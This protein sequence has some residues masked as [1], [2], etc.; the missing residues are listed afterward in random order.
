MLPFPRLGE[1]QEAWLGP[2]DGKP[3]VLAVH[4][5]LCTTVLVLTLKPVTPLL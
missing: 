4:E 3:L 1:G 5:A 2:L